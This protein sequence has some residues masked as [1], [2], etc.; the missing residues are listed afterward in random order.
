[1][2]QKQLFEPVPKYRNGTVVW[3][4]SEDRFDGLTPFE[5]DAKVLSS[6]SHQ[7][8]FYYSLITSRGSRIER[9]EKCVVSRDELLATKSSKIY[10][11]LEDTY[12]LSKDTEFFLVGDWVVNERYGLHFETE[13]FNKNLIHLFYVVPRTSM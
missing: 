3:F 10:S 4:K 1:M 12:G 13:Y 5:V 8:T 2:D 11:L 9:P 6:D 7:G